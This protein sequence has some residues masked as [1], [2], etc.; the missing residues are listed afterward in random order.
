MPYRKSAVRSRVCGT[1]NRLKHRGLTR[2]RSAGAFSTALPVSASKAV[3]VMP[4]EE[5]PGRHHIE[6]LEILIDRIEDLLQVRQHSAGELIDQERSTG[7]QQRVSFAKNDLANLSRY[8]G[9]G[10]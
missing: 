6:R 9:V 5:Q 10:D 1:L 4:A 8:G 7:V 2:H 3:G